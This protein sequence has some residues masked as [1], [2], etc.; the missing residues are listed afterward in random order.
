MSRNVKAIARIQKEME[1]MITPEI[2]QRLLENYHFHFK[3]L[4]FNHTFGVNHNWIAL[5][6]IK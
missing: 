5:N 1:R 2:R 6:N 3:C 4:T